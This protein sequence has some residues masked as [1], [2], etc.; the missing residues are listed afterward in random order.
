[1]ISQM[2]KKIESDLVLIRKFVSF[3]FRSLEMTDQFYL[4]ELL[5]KIIIDW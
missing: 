2:N 3:L 5:P 1:M 4:G